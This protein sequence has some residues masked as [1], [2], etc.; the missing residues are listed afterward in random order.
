MLVILPDD[1]FD[2]PLSEEINVNYMHLLLTFYCSKIK[3]AK[4]SEIYLMILQ[5]VLL[6]YLR[7]PFSRSK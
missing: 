1:L 6:N 7:S 3:E 4:G 5:K 2:L